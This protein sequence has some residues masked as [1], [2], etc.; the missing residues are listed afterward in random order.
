MHKWLS[1][2]LLQLTSDAGGQSELDPDAAADSTDTVEDLMSQLN[3][4]S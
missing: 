3:A 2:L 1:L 4:L